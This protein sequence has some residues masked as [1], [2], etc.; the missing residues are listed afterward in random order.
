MA[1]ASLTV[2]GTATYNDADYKLIWDDNN[3]G[4]SVVWLDYSNAKTDWG[5]QRVWAAGLSDELTINLN[6]YTVS[7][8]EDDWRLPTTKDGPYYYGYN[9]NHSTTAGCNIT[10]SEMGH[11]YHVELANMARYDTSGYRQDGYGLKETGEF[12]NLVSSQYWSGTE[13]GE[14]PTEAW[15]FYTSNGVQIKKN[16]DSYSFYGIAVRSG[17]V[18]AAPV[19]VPAAVWL[20]GSG[21]LGLVGTLRRMK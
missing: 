3:N 6:G 20:M 21:L 16:K 11:L 13:F 18:S 12:E 2:I 4:N 19:P 5:S 9:D 8:G 7:W 1:H 10:T 14:K 17:Q 15:V